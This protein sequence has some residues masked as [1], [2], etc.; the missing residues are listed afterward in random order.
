MKTEE[1]ELSGSEDKEEEEEENDKSDEESDDDGGDNGTL[2]NPVAELDLSDDNDGATKED[3]LH[4][5][6]FVDNIMLMWNHRRKKL[7][8]PFTLVGYLLYPHPDI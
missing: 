3:Q 6:G 7:I 1:E 5:E 8:T 2:F 4:L